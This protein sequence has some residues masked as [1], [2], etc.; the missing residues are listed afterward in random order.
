MTKQEINDKITL[1]EIIATHRAEFHGPNHASTLKANSMV[2][3]LL[4]EWLE[5]DEK[6]GELSN[7]S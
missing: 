7:E 5:L 3:S 4:N 1:W 2:K 6:M